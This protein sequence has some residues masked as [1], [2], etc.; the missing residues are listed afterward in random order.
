MAGRTS[1][2]G[3]RE[4]QGRARMNG[5]LVRAGIDSTDGCWNAPMRLVVRCEQM[6]PINAP[7]FCGLVPFTTDASD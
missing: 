1:W 4:P 3:C 6:I 2:Q 7:D 5:L